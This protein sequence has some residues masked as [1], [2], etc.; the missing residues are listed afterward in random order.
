MTHPIHPLQ[1]SSAFTELFEVHHLSVFRYIYACSGGSLQEAEDLAAETFLRA[2]KARHR[3][4]GDQNSALGWL[5]TIARH[6]VIDAARRN[7]V[8]SVDQSIA[9]IDE[10]QATHPLG[11]NISFENQAIHREQVALLH[12]KLSSLP[13]GRR[14][15]LVLRYVL[16]WQVKQ[17]AA[18]LGLSE[19][20]A[21]VY[22]RRALEQMRR[23][24]PPEEL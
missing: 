18:H 13:T 24:W 3:F 12:A 16:G 22:L 5:L 11:Y 1:D 20:T 2:W 4:E 9:D 17:I 21:S 14:E 10:W 23:D 7:K 8:R 15:L 19:N 6:L